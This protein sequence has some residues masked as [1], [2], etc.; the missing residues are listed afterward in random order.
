MRHTFSVGRARQQPQVASKPSRSTVPDAS[1][2]NSTNH[3]ARSVCWNSASAGVERAAGAAAAAAA[4]AAAPP[5]PPSPPAVSLEAGN[6][7]IS[8]GPG[9]AAAASTLSARHASTNRCRRAARPPRGR[10][11]RCRHAGSARST[12]RAHRNG[13]A[14]RLLL[15]LLLLLLPLLPVSF[16][17]RPQGPRRWP[18]RGVHRRLKAATC[19]PATRS[20]TEASARSW[21][22]ERSS[23]SRLKLSVQL[24]RVRAVEPHS[25]QVLKSGALL[26][27][28][29][30]SATRV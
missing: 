20:R 10:R 9:A 4:A 14:V 30:W 15:L 21:S 18:A 7:R 27:E 11:R 1:S 13:L 25:V 16:S 6:R 3:A 22:A 2:S 23:K 19:S 28:R 24:L 12:R 17:P 26:A 29:R 8:G 5:P